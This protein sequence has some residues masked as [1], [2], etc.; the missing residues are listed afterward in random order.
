MYIYMLPRKFVPNIWVPKTTSITICSSI[1]GKMYF[2]MYQTLHFKEVQLIINQLYLC[3]AYE[4]PDK[5]ES[6]V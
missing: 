3:K 6:K 2:K 5:S 4:N 1:W